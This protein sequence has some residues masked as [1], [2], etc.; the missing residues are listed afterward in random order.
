MLNTI[1]SRFAQ[2]NHLAIC[3]TQSPRDMLSTITS[4][5][6]Q[7]SHLLTSAHDK[8]QRQALA[9]HT[10]AVTAWPLQCTRY[11]NQL[12]NILSLRTSDL[13][14]SLFCPGE[15]GGLGIQQVATSVNL[16]AQRTLILN[17]HR[18]VGVQHHV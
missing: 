18:R 8:A 14:A 15:A 6:A 1:T 3:S 16:S 17:C 5:F 2:N 4:R 7:H 10:T 12:Q 13:Q 9:M 11:I